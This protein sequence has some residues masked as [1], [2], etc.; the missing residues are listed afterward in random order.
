[1]RKMSAT[2][3]RPSPP[4]INGGEGEDL[5][6]EWFAAKLRFRIEGQLGRR[7]PAEAGTPNFKRAGNSTRL[8]LFTLLRL[9][10]STAALLGGQAQKKMVWLGVAAA[11]G[12][13]SGGDSQYHF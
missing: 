13:D 6:C 1:M 11:G 7:G 10:F 12:V 3:P 5:S 9:T 2:S 4:F 8:V